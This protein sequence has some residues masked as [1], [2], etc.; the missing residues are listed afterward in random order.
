MRS[1]RNVSAFL[2][3]LTTG[4]APRPYA[5]QDGSVKTTYIHQYGVEVANVDEWNERGASGQIVKQHKNGAAE[6]QSWQQGKLH[7]LSTVTFP[8]A[9]T[10]HT[11]TYYD[12][13]AIV[14]QTV[15]YASGMP[16]RQNIYRPGNV[17]LVSTWYEDGAPRSSEEYHGS[18]LFSG[19]Y[20]TRDQE[21]ESQVVQGA[22]ERLR[23][24]GHGQLISKDEFEN[25]K[26]ILQ[27]VYYPNGMP[28]KYIPFVN[29]QIEGTL[30]TFYPGGEPAT[31][32]SWKA[33]K[34]HGDTIV[35]RGGERVS[36][37]P[38]VDGQKEGIETGFRPGTDTVTEQVSWKNSQKHGPSTFWVDQEKII[39]YYFDGQ[40]VSK[41]D[42]ANRQMKY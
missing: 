7:G 22:G 10:L 25:G 4:C 37:V 14:W 16:K 27:V 5:S 39:E 19:E 23:R 2:L 33:N 17:S 32:E 28:Q 3:L 9:S 35:F 13:G 1:Y 20:F 30:K 40:K 11:E 26:K 34:Q 38:Y 42:F 29:D 6:T 41:T 21:L 24:D 31:A 36:I 8:H 15:H 18:D 12:K